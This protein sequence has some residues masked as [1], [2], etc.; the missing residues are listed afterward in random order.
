MK[1]TM[2]AAR[3]HEWGGTLTIDEVP[4]PD[5]DDGDVLVEVKACDVNGGDPHFIGQDIRLTAGAEDTTP[6]RRLPL[7]LG[8]HAAGVVA[9]AGRAAK[10]HVREGDRV[11]VQP[12]IRCGVCSYCRDGELCDD[13]GVIGFTI[14]AHTDYGLWRAEE[15]YREGAYADYVK[16]PVENILGLP[17]TIP[18]DQACKMSQLS[19]A[20][21]G[22]EVAEVRAGSTVIVNGAS[23]GSGVPALMACKFL[24]AGMIIAIG[25]RRERLE[26]VKRLVGSNLIEII[27]IDENIHDRIMELTNGTGADALLDYGPGDPHST[28]QCVYSLRRHAWVVLIG[29]ATSELPLSYRYIMSK[30]MRITGCHTTINTIVETMN[31]V[32]GGGLDCSKL[33]THRFPLEEVNEALDVLRSGADNAIWV[34]VEP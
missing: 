22:A 34:V 31:L 14:T 11:V 32:A 10:L 20:F 16:V 30:E 8:H 6:I 23:G 24:G 2:R 13:G 18:F 9:K 27:T 17:D 19:L 15:K 5:V 1:S 33:V 7:T 21:R 12:G 28:Q 25:R 4:T 3:L 26:S 29:G